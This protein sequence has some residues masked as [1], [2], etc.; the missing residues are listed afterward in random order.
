MIVRI[1]DAES[2]GIPS[3]TE[4]H[5]MVEGGWTDFD[6]DSGI[7][8]SP[9]SMLC[10]PGR[11]IPVEAQAI[12]HIRDCDVVGAP[13]PDKVCEAISANVATDY[14]AAFNSAFD[15]QFFGGADKQWI[16]V[17][18]SAL[19]VWPDA[20]RHNNQTLRYFLGID[21]LPDFNREH[22]EPSHRA[23]PDSYVTAF[24]LRELLKRTDIE[25]VLKWS[26]GP[27]LLSRVRFGKHFGMKWSEVPMSYLTWI[28][29][30]D[31]TDRDIRATA[32]HYLKIASARRNAQ[33]E[34]T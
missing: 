15:Q 13:T 32:K 29:Q 22:A 30:S 16:C 34:T 26:A 24:I 7:I 17:Y 14:Y 8:S 21:D 25:N 11:P 4:T 2:T 1:F 31:I 12:H 3:E 10:N 18:K 19:R 9:S 5:A 33:K 20:P 27:A 6:T 23:G 28:G